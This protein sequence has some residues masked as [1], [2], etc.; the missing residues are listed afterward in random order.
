MSSFVSVPM[1]L[2]IEGSSV[3][4]LFVMTSNLETAVEA[5]NVLPDLPSLIAPGSSVASMFVLLAMPGFSFVVTSTEPPFMIAWS[6]SRVAG[7][8][9][10]CNNLPG[11][12]SVAAI[13]SFSFVVTRIR[14]E[15]GS[16]V[17]TGPFVVI[18]AVVFAFVV[19]ALV[20]VGGMKA[21]VVEGFAVV[22]FVVVGACVVGFRQINDPAVFTQL[23]FDT[24]LCK[25]RSHSS[26]SA[27]KREL[28]V[29]LKELFRNVQQKLGKFCMK[30]Q[31]KCL[32]KY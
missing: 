8:S 17:E 13:V 31:T 30:F 4:S 2:L 12:T 16:A 25:P 15:R 20:V 3:A 11:V 6:T 23:S 22:V 26:M 14:A 32:V 5:I 24:Q 19:V 1:T 10:D 28:K 21:V 27:N 7:W 29:I 18:S 9:V